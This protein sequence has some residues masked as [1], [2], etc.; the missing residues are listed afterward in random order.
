MLLPVNAHAPLAAWR[1]HP[2][3]R[4]GLVCGA[5]AWSRTYDPER[6]VRRLAE[7]RA[8]G[9][10]TPVSAVAGHVRWPCPA[11]RRMR[12]KSVLVGPE[13]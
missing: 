13:L 10:A 1:A 7:R 5:C 2:G 3:S 8:G 9:P 4:L 12:W 11:C 6:I